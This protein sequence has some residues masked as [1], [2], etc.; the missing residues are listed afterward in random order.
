MLKAI[1]TSWFLAA[2]AFFVLPTAVAQAASEFKACTRCHGEQ[3]NSDD[4]D[5][6]L[7]AGLS[8]AY[9]DAAMRGYREGRRECGISKM[10]CRMAAKWTDEEIAIAA[11]HFAQ[12]ERVVPE[13][14][15]DSAL[16]AKGEIIHQ[17]NCA[18]CHS[19]EAEASPDLQPAG[20][21]NGQ[22]REYLEYSLE[23]YA[24][25]GR[26]QPED[27]R[28]ALEALSEDQMEALL[29]YYASGREVLPCVPGELCAAE[30]RQSSGRQDGQDQGDF[31]GAR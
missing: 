17:D 22:W 3:G 14:P 9:S 21:L 8:V 6:P 29:D 18:S 28:S 23:Q 24:S 19:A 25:G 7:I 2:A 15:F 4:S 11:G 1:I 26:Q 20:T 13:Q 27:M 16:A 5:I 10:K 12:F 31:P 30:F